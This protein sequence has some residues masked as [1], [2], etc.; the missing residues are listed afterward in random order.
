MKDITIVAHAFGATP[1]HPRWITTADLNDDRK[2]DIL[3]ITTIAKAWGKT[4]PP[5]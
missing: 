1:G 5:P 4:Y 2:I 3:D